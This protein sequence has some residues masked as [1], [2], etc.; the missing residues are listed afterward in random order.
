MVDGIKDTSTIIDRL[1]AGVEYTFKVY[2]SEKADNANSLNAGNNKTYLG[3]ATFTTEGSKDTAAIAAKDTEVSLAS[4][5]YTCAQAT[6][7]GISKDDTRIRGY[8]IYANG[9]L[10]KTLYNYQINKYDTVDTISNQV[11]RLTPGI[12]NKVQIVAFTDAG[13]EYKYPEATVKTLENYDYKAP[14]WSSDAAVTA[15]ENEAGDIVLTWDAA[16]DDTKVGGYR[17][18]L[19]GVAYISDGVTG[20]GI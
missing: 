12:E 9:N 3:E 4:A 14:V 17:V 6:W 18:Y 15:K 2:V 7:T 13:V 20:S 19:D 10:V 11:G 8:K 5:I 1:S 16:T